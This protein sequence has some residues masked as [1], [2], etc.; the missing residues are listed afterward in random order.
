MHAYSSVWCSCA[1]VACAFR[2]AKHS[3]GFT[4]KP[5]FLSWQSVVKS[6]MVILLDEFLMACQQFSFPL[7]NFPSFPSIKCNP[8]FVW[9]AASLTL[10]ERK[11]EGCAQYFDIYKYHELVK[12]RLVKWSSFGG[13]CSCSIILSIVFITVTFKICRN[14]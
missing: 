2:H 13:E 12:R 14:W 4:V 7:S 1:V 3:Y 8:P 6:H 10:P 5:F 11:Q 9:L